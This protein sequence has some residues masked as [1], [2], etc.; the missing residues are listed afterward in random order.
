MK[1]W[2]VKVHDSSFERARITGDCQVA[3]CEYIW[4]GFEAGATQVI[5]QLIGASLKEPTSIKVID[6]GAG[7]AYEKLADSFEPF[8]STDKNKESIRIKS[9]S[10]QGKGRFS[11]LC[12]SE[13]VKWES[14]YMK[15]NELKKYSITMNSISK[16]SFTTSDVVDADSGER[17]GTIVEIPISDSKTRDRLS[18]SNIQQKL[19]REFSW[20]LYLN[21]TK[22]F[23]LEY[24]GVSLNFEQYINT[25][26]SLKKTLT[27][28][29]QSF[30]VNL[31]V[32]KSDIGNTS[33]IFYLDSNGNIHE[34]D[35]TGYNRNMVGFYHNVFISSD[36]VNSITKLS[37]RNPEDNDQASTEKETRAIFAQLKREVVAL[38]EEIFKN[39]IRPRA[40]EEL[41]AMEKRGS[42]PDFPQNEY[43][44]H[45]KKDLLKVTKELYIVE[46]RIFFGL[47][48]KQEKSLLGFLNLLL[49]T[50]E[51]ENIINILEHILALTDE[52]RK[53]FADILQRTKLEYILDVVFTI[54]RRLT[55]IELLK[56]IV[57]DMAKFANERN[58]IQ[59]IM[60]QHFWL[61]GEQYHMLTYDKT[62]A[63]SLKEHETITN[64]QQHNIISNVDSGQNLRQRMDVFLYTQHGLEDGNTE[65]LIIELKAPSVHLS[66][67]VYNQV[68]RY[69]NTVRKL[70]R[71]NSPQRLWRFYAVC[72]TIDDDVKVMYKNFKQYGKVGLVNLIDDH[73]EIYALTWDDVF[74]SFESRNRFLLNRLKVDTTQLI[75]MIEGDENNAPSRE[76][77]NEISAKITF[78]QTR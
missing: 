70:P 65:M 75:D 69:A 37:A 6:N 67:D 60:N 51:R 24:L 38:L 15:G 10:H 12:F 43:G 27:I 13:C 55:V 71:F 29:S 33:K 20:F 53:S 16:S 11:Y 14:V 78:M 68:V 64:T 21:K 48:P 76:L 57:F 26:L 61:F 63:T 59:K 22:N 46:P 32:W 8:L 9:K 40:D 18:M 17:T 72:A 42:M 77:V 2:Q 31:I 3:I 56:K 36:F 1:H 30:Q 66:L 4:N 35:N 41:S 34:S 23:N 50:D 45:R 28:Q 39:F 44:Q 54:D 58:H 5:V 47:H 74:Q 19:L 52:Q 73:F 7:I 62:L 49:S 25:E